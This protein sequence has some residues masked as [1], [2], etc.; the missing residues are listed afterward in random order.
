M[1]ELSLVQSLLDIVE[2][3]ARRENFSQVNVLRISFGRLSCLDPSSL[4]FAFE[5]LSEGTK[6][7]G[8]RLEFDI[9]PA[10]LTCAACGEESACDGPCE[11]QCPC[12]GSEKVCLTGGTE[13][14]QL[15]EMD[16]D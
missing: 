10:R 9:R 2:D 16:V 4:E 3:Y 13:E 15:K 11:M 12:C 6:A 1:H 5:V 7:K 8:A 14:L